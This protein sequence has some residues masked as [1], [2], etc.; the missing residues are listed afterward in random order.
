M[1]ELHLVF[2][3]NH[4]RACVFAALG[5]RPAIELELLDPLLAQFQLG[6]TFG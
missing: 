2:L 1:G 5:R 3:T 4:Q 6:L